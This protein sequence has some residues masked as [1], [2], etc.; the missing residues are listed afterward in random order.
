MA[1]F[2]AVHPVDPPVPFPSEGFEAV[3]RKCKSWE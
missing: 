2:L 3:A 1:K